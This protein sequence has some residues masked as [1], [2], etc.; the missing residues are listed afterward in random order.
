M[1]GLGDVYTIRITM[2][3]ENSNSRFRL[4]AIIAATGVVLT[5]GLAII[6]IKPFSVKSQLPRTIFR[7]TS[8][9]LYHPN[10]SQDN[11]LYKS[12]ETKQ[13]QDAV[14]T[15]FISSSGKLVLTQQTRAKIDYGRF[16]VLEKYGIE[17]GTVYIIKDI[18]DKI[19]AIVD[20]SGTLILLSADKD[21][22]LSVVKAFIGRLE[23]QKE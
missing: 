18:P 15:T 10:N 9:G 6:L 20:T 1:H 8:F 11:L 19:Q 23:L 21:I 22:G 5:L 12:D 13:L 7:T 17:T 2:P 14:F 4:I 3:E 16:D